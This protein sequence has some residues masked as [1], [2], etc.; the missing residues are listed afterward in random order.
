MVLVLSNVAVKSELTTIITNYLATNAVASWKIYDAAN[1]LIKSGLEI[2]DTKDTFRAYVAEVQNYFNI[3]KDSL[4]AD[5]VTKINSISN[6]HDLLAKSDTL[7]GIFRRTKGKQRESGGSAE[8]TKEPTRKEKLKDLTSLQKMDQIAME[9]DSDKKVFDTKTKISKFYRPFMKQIKDDLNIKLK[10]SITLQE[11]EMLLKISQC[12]CLADFVALKKDFV[13]NDYDAGECKYIKKAVVDATYLWESKQLEHTDHLEDWYRINLYTFIWDSLYLKEDEFNSKRSECHSNITK[14]LNNTAKEKVQNQNIDFILR[15]KN[16]QLDFL[17]VEE[18]KDLSGVKADVEKGK[19]M[20][21]YVLDVWK[22]KLGNKLPLLR[23]L[24]SISCQWKAN[25]I[26]IY[27][28]K[29]LPSGKYLQYI[30]GQY[31]FPNVP[32]HGSEF[33][34]LL[35][36]MISLK[37]LVLLNYRKFN[38][39]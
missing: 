39:I 37:R 14:Y 16:D 35:M 17:T 10:A 4:H 27:G 13:L 11:Q 38:H 36:Y 18:K 21:A 31:K 23:E 9:D 5:E 32:S 22:H 29:L 24:E 3:N 7:K 28:S 15:S 8:E 12:T 26:T 2:I 1:L 19:L 30:K 25:E 34:K 6:S 33:A 20:Q